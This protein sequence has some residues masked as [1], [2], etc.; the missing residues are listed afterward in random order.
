MRFMGGKSKIANE[1]APIILRDNPDL[2]IEPFCGA[3]NVT[4]A[5]VKLK[6]SLQVL[7]SDSHKDLI[8]L[9]VAVQNGWEPPSHISKE[10][11]LE[12]KQSPSSPLR[13]F[14]GY[15]CSFSG[16]WWEGYASDSLGRNYCGN[17]QRSIEKMRPFLLGVEF[18]HQ[19]Y[20]EVI[21]QGTVYCDP[22]YQSTKAPGEKKP[23]D[24]LAF[25][26]WVKKQSFPVFV[27]EYE[28]ELECIWQKNVRTDMHTSKGQAPRIERLFFHPSRT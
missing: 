1:I 22:P 19:S 28:S 16:R 6:P 12:L 27:S 10:Q 2:I 3:L 17:A 14:V 25:W 18:S 8:D 21:I 9:W 24:S 13:T 11:Y 15:G 26:A 5:L 4:V 20:D 23:F 7:A